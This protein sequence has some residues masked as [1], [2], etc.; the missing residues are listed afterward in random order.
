MLRAQSPL[1]N[2]KYSL[3]VLRL[4]QDQRFRKCNFQNGG[5][6]DIYRCQK[7]AMFELYVKS[8]MCVNMSN[9]FVLYEV[10]G[11]TNIVKF[12]VVCPY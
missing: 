12:D 2:R 4:N 5:G 10:T 8:A 9:Y 1:I 6:S 3:C 7:C 11:R